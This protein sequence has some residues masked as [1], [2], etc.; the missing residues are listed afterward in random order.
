MLGIPGVDIDLGSYPP[1]VL[2]KAV[3]LKSDPLE[4]AKWLAQAK[5]E[6]EHLLVKSGVVTFRDFALSNAS[7]FDNFLSCFDGHRAG[8]AGGTSPRSKV[9]GRV[10]QSTQAPPDR[11]IL[12]HQEMAYTRDFPGRLAFF[13][14][15]PPRSGGE[16]L[17]G[18]MRKFTAE[19]PKAFFDKVKKLG[20]RY[21]RR[22]RNPDWKPGH[23][24]LDVLHR[25]WVD[26]FGSESREDAEAACRATGSDCTWTEHGMEASFTTP[27]YV[28][29][30]VTGEEIWFNVIPAFD[31]NAVSQGKRFQ[32]LHE[33]YYGA[34]HPWPQAV[35]FGDGT[36]FLREEIEAL[37]PI[38][39]SVT[40]APKWQRG[41]VQLLDNIL[42]GHGRATFTGQRCV[43]VMLLA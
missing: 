32:D 34:A 5:P 28:T 22:F 1:V 16:T 4:T 13:C 18:D 40:T 7:Q 30:P 25:S 29:H 6:I 35:T 41:D 37:Y 9:A 2:A 36:E 3:S 42:T 17:I 21:V 27:G 26:A 14:E 8:Y 10:M 31:L 38:V 39:D 33:Q 12:L 19:V 43:R 15:I 23:L 24:D 20:V 11:E